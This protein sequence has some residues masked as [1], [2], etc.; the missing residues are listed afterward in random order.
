[1]T[2]D[3]RAL[4][5]AMAASLTAP[6]LARAASSQFDLPVA[7]RTSK[8]TVWTPATPRAAVVFSHGGNSWPAQY[9]GLAE[10]LVGQGYAVY[11]PLHTDSLQMP[12]DQ[13]KDLQAAFGDRVADMAT[14]TGFVAARSP[15]LPIVAMGHS[16]GSLI[17]LMLGG[18]L[19]YAA[20]IHNP[21]VKAMVCYSSPG[22]IP[23]LINPASFQTLK[24][25]LLMI[26][27]DQDL[28]PGW[29]TDWHAHELPFEGTPV[30]ESYE[31]VVTGGD[32]KLVARA[33]ASADLARDVTLQFLQ[34]QLFASGRPLSLP[35]GAAASLRS[36]KAP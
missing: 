24:V 36:K 11:A 13:Q 2:L 28:V 14:L 32:H 1:M 7:G 5:A 3:R 27:G 30:S 29:V 19:E 8:V 18:A 6:G 10:W 15:G 34:R 17:A 20:K 9:D 25:P 35:A 23:G 21:A 26:T 4:L 22:A 12:K 33:D 16:L 31:L